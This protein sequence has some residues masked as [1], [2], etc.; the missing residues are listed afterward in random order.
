MKA[1][2]RSSTG[3]ASG[4]FAYRSMIL[5]FILMWIDRAIS[6]VCGPTAKVCRVRMEPFKLDKRA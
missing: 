5:A 1:R 2:A 3:R 4:W 6:T